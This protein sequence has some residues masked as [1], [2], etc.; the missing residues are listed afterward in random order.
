MVDYFTP[1]NQLKIG[2]PGQDTDLG[3]G[4]VIL[5]DDQPTGPPH[6]L[7]IAGKEGVIYLIDR[8]KMG[9]FDS[10]KDNVVA[11]LPVNPADASLV[12][13]VFSMPTLFGSSIFLV[14]APIRDAKCPDGGALGPNPMREFQLSGGK[15]TPAKST[16]VM[17]GWK[18]CTPAVSASGTTNGIVW[19]V[20]A[21]GFRPTVPSILHA[22]DATDLGKELYNTEQAVTAAGAK[23]DQPGIGIKFSV[24]R[25]PT[26][27]STSVPSARS[28]STARSALER[29]RRPRRVATL[30][31]YRNRRI[32]VKWHLRF[33]PLVG[34]VASLLWSSA[35][36]AQCTAPAAVVPAFQHAAAE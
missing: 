8:D 36:L 26:A 10:T 28:P 13:D 18:T 25:S 33:A 31:C 4:G 32:I 19:L 34:L 30:S 21:E 14:G 20:Q 35:A 12:G 22:F 16:T 3:S 23:R 29:G 2:G 7:A 9:K 11:R 6:L 24:P 1:F 17:F 15:L 5:L 27:K